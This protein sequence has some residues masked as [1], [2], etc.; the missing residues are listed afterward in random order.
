MFF[1]LLKYF[2][3]AHPT[4]NFTANLLTHIELLDNFFFAIHAGEN[5]FKSALGIT[6]S[7][8]IER[9]TGELDGDETDNP[10]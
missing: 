2:L 5:T 1:Y 8:L 6:Q 3:F 9:E 4:N 10:V 7:S